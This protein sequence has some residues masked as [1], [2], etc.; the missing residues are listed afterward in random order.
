MNLEEIM[1]LIIGILFVFMPGIGIPLVAIIVLV[2]TIADK[3]QIPIK[4]TYCE[5]P[6]DKYE[7]VD[8]KKFNLMMKI[9]G[10]SFFLLI[11]LTLYLQVWSLIAMILAVLHMMIFNYMLEKYY[12]LRQV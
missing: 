1:R 9:R 8:E 5:L 2:T 7:I 12:K 6:K 4:D 10:Y 3:N 11:F